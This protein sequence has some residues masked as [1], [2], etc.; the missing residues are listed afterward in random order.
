MAVDQQQA[1]QDRA[2][3]P[4]RGDSQPQPDYPAP[5]GQPQ[6]YAPA[7]YPG[8]P[9]PQQPLPQQPMPQEPPRHHVHHSYIWL[10]SIQAGAAMFFVVLVSGFS[11][12][13]GALADG[14]TIGDDLPLL[15]LVIGAIVLGL[16]LI[17]GLVALFQWLSYKHLYYIIGPEEF[18]LYSGIFNKKR[19]H[20][21]YQRIQSVDQRAS[22]LQRVFGVCTVSID[23]AGGSNNKAVQVPYVQKSQAEQLRTELF[24][25]KQYATAVQEGMAPQE[26]AVAVAAASGVVLP[27]AGAA[28]QAAVAGSAGQAPHNV[29][30]APAEIWTDVRGVFGGSAV[31]TGKVTYEYGLTNK[32]LL[33]TGLSNN[34]AFVLVILGILGGAAQF[35]SQMAPVLTGMVDPLVGQFMLL[36]GQ[37]FGGNLVAAGVALVLV[38]AAVMWLLSIVGSAISFGGFRACRRDNRIE[39]ERGLL[40]HQF[41]GVSVDRVQSVIVKQSFIRRLL[42][43]CELSLGKI[44][45]AAES[46]DE[47]QKSLSQGLVVH[48]FVKMSRVPEILAGLVPEFAGVPVESTPVA[49]VALRRALIRRGIIQGT[50]LWLAVI[51]AI[52]QLC[53]NA[54]IVPDGDGVIALFYINTGAFI[55]YALCLVLFVL[56]L[57]GAVLWF[58]GSGFAYNEH[59]MQ[60][61]NGGFARE[62]VSFPRKK[63][64]FGYTKTNPFQRRART[65]TVSAR[66]AAGVGGTTIRLIDVCE[67]DARSWLDWLKPRGN[68]VE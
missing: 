68:V 14:E 9:Y 28:G 25:R 18:N 12:F 39:V 13:V 7:P 27:Q 35:A 11:G 60:V 21:P 30:D 16:V 66:T 43:Y 31:D 3:Q 46:S 26:A 41:Q 51:I 49:P 62:T 8:Q 10:G 55:G 24:A 42:G 54:F 15:M 61:S 44:D 1:P 5:Y 22:L 29:L 34:T 53:S 67:E 19:V 63:I 56:D 20:V 50:G 64:Q 58:R 32:E 37:L 40:Q 6:P 52:G 23:T 45:A 4:S 33:F 17:I 47:Q 38:I 65:A 48:P 57:V 59:F 36:S 2:P